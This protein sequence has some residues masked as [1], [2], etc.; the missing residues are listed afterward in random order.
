MLKL[1]KLP[2]QWKVY[3]CN[4]KYIAIPFIRHIKSLAEEVQNWTC[5][6][7]ISRLIKNTKTFYLED[8][9][10]TSVVSLIYV[11]QNWVY[12]DKFSELIGYLFSLLICINRVLFQPNW[13]LTRFDIILLFQLVPNNQLFSN[14]RVPNF[15]DVHKTGI[16]K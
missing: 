10:R 14:N 1:K 8:H 2:R 6:N 11:R 13:N 16:S 3:V 4:Y 12:F 9:E 7:F 5:V 15:P